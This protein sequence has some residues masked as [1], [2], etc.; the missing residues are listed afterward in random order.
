V[1]WVH[2]RPF[3]SADIAQFGVFQVRRRTHNVGRHLN[4]TTILQSLRSTPIFISNFI[5]NGKES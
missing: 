3:T 4:L 5:V 2:T 1:K